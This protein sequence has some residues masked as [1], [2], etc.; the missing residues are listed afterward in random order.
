[1]KEIICIVC[2]KGCHLKVDE[3]KDYE[4]TGFGC[5]RG[6]EYGR[7]ELIAPTRTVTSTVRCSGALY[8]RCPVKTDRPVPKQSIPD[9]MEALNHADLAAP[10]TLGQ[11]VLE[12]VCGTGANI[13]ATRSLS[14]V[15][16][17]T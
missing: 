16:G 5:P 11:V 10:V 3:K 1:M 13:I 7:T 4:V 17:H 12:N 8:P 15:G 14:P 2:P 6:K 9:I